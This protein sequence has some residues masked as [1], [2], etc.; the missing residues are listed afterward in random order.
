MKM[1]DGNYDEMFKVMITGQDPTGE[2]DVKG[3]QKGFTIDGPGF[4]V[5]GDDRD[6]N[7]DLAFPTMFEAIQWYM[8]WRSNLA[9]FAIRKGD[10]VT[11]M[12]DRVV[13]TV[14]PNFTF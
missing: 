1:R 5:H 4:N 13:M 10:S 7:W 2:W 12:N 8:T 11:D 6:G 14:T 9:G 3:L